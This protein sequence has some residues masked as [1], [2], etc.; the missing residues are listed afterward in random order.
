[1]ISYTTPGP[2]S[3]NTGAVFFPML[4]RSHEVSRLFSKQC[5]PMP[6]PKRRTSHA[7]PMMWGL[8]APSK[9][10]FNSHRR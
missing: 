7:D 9:E 2:G 8:A 10:L 3:N 5:V 1:M 6:V 4:L